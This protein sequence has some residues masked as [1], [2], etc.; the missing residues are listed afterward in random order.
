MSHD[1]SIHR[2]ESHLVILLKHTVL[3]KATLNERAVTERA[4]RVARRSRSRRSEVCGRASLA[5]AQLAQLDMAFAMNCAAAGWNGPTG[6]GTPNGSVLNGGG[7]CA[8]NCAGKSCGDDGC[9]GTC[10]TCGPDQT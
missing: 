5:R 10:G 3:N 7:T 6:M 1:A 2:R 8:P 4:T 9:G